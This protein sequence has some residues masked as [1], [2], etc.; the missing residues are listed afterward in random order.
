MRVCFADFTLDLAT[1]EL[2]RGD[3]P[4]HLS[5][6]A[7]ELLVHLTEASPR[8]LAKHEI[9]DLVWPATFISE[10]TLAG[11]VKEVRACLGDDAHEPRFVRTVYGF[12]YAFSA[13]LSRTADAAPR[14]N[15]LT[16]RL[17]WGSRE[18]VLARGPNII[19]RGGESVVWI[20]DAS[21]SRQH[22]VIA[23]SDA[24][25]T[26]EDLDSKNG[27]FVQGRRIA[28]RQQLADG[29]EVIL[30][31]VPMIFRLFREGTSTE[32]LHAR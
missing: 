16:W 24:D 22:A 27:T 26:I 4:V 12:G 6:K 30:G 1:R 13:D 7:F 15:E 29:D 20:D 10:A 18:I 28:Q 2:R 17:I 25:V 32:S 14:R 5:P 3:D 11:V 19:G 9:Q 31:R 21:V 23:V 8:A